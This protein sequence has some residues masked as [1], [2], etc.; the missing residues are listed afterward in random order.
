V[1]L[2]KDTVLL[3]GV[4]LRI[5]VSDRPDISNLLPS[6]LNRSKR[7]GS[8]AIGCVPLASPRLSKDGNQLIENG[9]TGDSQNEEYETVDAGQA[10]KED[11]F[12][13]GTVA[14]IIGVQR[15][16]YSEPALVVEGVR[17]FTVVKILKERPFFE[18]E[19]V[20]HD[21]PGECLHHPDA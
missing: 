4:T 2:P 7:D 15:R 1:P 21:E 11:L 6:L 9:N 10:R 12:G 8:I 3:P 17:R 16:A 18:G 13:F 14:K 5:P 20:L 19:V